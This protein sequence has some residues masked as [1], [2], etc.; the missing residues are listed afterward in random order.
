[1]GILM[2]LWEWGLFNHIVRCLSMDFQGVRNMGRN[3]DASGQGFEGSIRHIRH[4]D[5]RTCRL[6]TFGRGSATKIGGPVRQAQSEG[7]GSSI[8]VRR[9]GEIGIIKQNGQ[10]F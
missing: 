6:R 5:R 8:Q 2:G 10:G 7:M 9:V 1:M 3:K 4:K